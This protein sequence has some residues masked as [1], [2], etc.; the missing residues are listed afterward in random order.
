MRNLK[1]LCVTKVMSD[2]AS[3]M[4]SERD[5]LPID[6]KRECKGGCRWFSG[7]FQNAATKRNDSSQ[8]VIEKK[9]RK[10]NVR[11]NFHFYQGFQ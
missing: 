11:K 3:L 5:F 2:R 4:E 10:T 1:F 6:R 9:S 7:E 8:V